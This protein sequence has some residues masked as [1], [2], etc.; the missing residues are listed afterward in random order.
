[1]ILRA[2]ISVPSAANRTLPPILRAFGERYPGVEPLLREVD[3]DRLLRALGD[4]RVDVDFLWQRP[5]Y[6]RSFWLGLR[7]KASWREDSLSGSQERKEAGGGGRSEQACGASASPVDKRRA[8]RSSAQHSSAPK[9]AGRLK[10]DEGAE[11]SKLKR[12]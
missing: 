8:L 4:G 12:R 11:R 1:M 10:R 3:P 6:P 5:L 2:P 9:A 7:P